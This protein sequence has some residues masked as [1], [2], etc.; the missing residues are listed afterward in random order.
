MLGNAASVAPAFANSEQRAWGNGNHLS[1]KQVRATMETEA[2][3]TSNGHRG[4]TRWPGWEGG[5]EGGGRS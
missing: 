2:S 4:T 5:T 3:S 1:N